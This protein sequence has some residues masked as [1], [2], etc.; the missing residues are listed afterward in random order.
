ML[1]SKLLYEQEYTS[2]WEAKKIA[3]TTIVSN[4]AQIEKGCVFVCLKGQRYD[5]HGQMSYLFQSG[6]AAVVVQKGCGFSRIPA[7]PI[8][9]VEDS[10]LM[11]SLMWNRFCGNPAQK[12]RF[13][14]I[15]GTNG[16]TT[17]AFIIHHILTTASIKAALIGTVTC[18][19]GQSR[20]TPS[21]L[22]PK[23]T[24]FETMT[25]PDPDLLYPMLAEMVEAGVTY[26]VMEVSSHALLFNKVAPIQ[27][28]IGIFT[29]LSPEHLD[30]HGTIEA[31]MHAK[32]KL[33]SQ[34]EVALFNAD[35]PASSLL[36]GESRAQNR[37]YALTD[38]ADFKAEH[39]ACE[40]HDG[41]SFTFASKK[42]VFPIKSPLCGTFNIYNLL[43]GC[44]VAELLQISPN[45]IKQA[46]F[47]M[48]AIPGRM[49]KVPLPGLEF[50]VYI[51]FAHTENAMRHLLSSVRACCTAQQRVVVLFG[52]GG[53]RDKSKRAQMGACAM[54]MADFSII[55]SDNA[56]SEDPKQIITDILKG[57]PKVEKRRVIL[58][59]KK[60]I[61]YAIHNAQRGDVILLVGK[62]HETY[63]LTGKEKRPFDE[64]KIV[65][66]AIEMR[67]AAHTTCES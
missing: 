58:S 20:Y 47:T 15:T 31:Y 8:F 14:G 49:E 50:E 41:I 24:R 44:A 2:A 28:D 16:K 37:T 10:R 25:T 43:A 45:D 18:K 62:G 19:I 17:T 6:V 13:I 65:M 34:S 35:D 61:E 9:E 56:R 63:E 53:D 52:C 67:K 4:T 54:E 39:T 1:L 33:F 21:F 66:K 38:D 32:S 48:D 60:A 23:D 22:Q 64:R 27:F 5:P 29:N 7:L 57:F 42:H 36:L 40:G 11:L 3:V 12:L 59:R 30:M 46:L 55:T 51:D 26:V